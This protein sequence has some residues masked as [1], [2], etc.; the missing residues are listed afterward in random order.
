MIDEFLKT[1]PLALCA[2]INP[3]GILILI[4][5]LVAGTDRIKRSL[6]F[7]FGF[8]VTFFF[9]GILLLLAIKEIAS[10]IKIDSAQIMCDFDWAIL[11]AV[12][13]YF[14]YKLIKK[15]RHEEKENIEKQK[16]RSEGFGSWL[17]YGSLYALTDITS[18]IP[19]M[20]LLK[21]VATTKLDF[22]DKSMSILLTN[23][24]VTIPLILLPLI[25]VIFPDKSNA[26]LDK[27]KS[28]LS[29]HK[30]TISIIILIIIVVY[31]LFKIS[32]CLV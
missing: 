6:A 1:L 24:V 7:V 21:D 5:V 16:N 9:I 23:V 12:V 3:V 31:L 8:F 18:L 10:T 32:K 17:I 19:Y 29:S 27:L 2:A 13:I 14:G 4:A 28:A 22:L 11:A 15:N 25:C 20:I 26:I 30:K